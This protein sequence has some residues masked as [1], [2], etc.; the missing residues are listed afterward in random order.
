MNIGIGMIFTPLW[1]YILKDLEK[2]ANLL[3]LTE[4]RVKMK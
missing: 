3:N 2:Y 1:V 4:A